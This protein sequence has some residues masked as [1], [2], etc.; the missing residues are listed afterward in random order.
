MK[1]QGLAEE[2]AP[3]TASSSTVAR[4]ASPSPEVAER[5]GPFVAPATS[6]RGRWASIRAVLE[7]ATPLQMAGIQWFAALLMVV[8]VLCTP[9][10]SR[11]GLLSITETY[12][13]LER[14]ALWQRTF[15][16]IPGIMRDG[17][18][19][20]LPPGLIVYS[21]RFGMILLFGLQALAFWQAWR[22][23][24]VSFARWLIG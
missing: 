16:W 4:P 13:S 20:H 3:F 7:R 8:V 18:F 5:P 6:T 17:E 19:L 9:T 23:R 1:V 11:K 14:V 24:H 12:G 10:T 21:F 22:G 2:S 15:D